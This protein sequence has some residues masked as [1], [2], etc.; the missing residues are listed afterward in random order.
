[1]STIWLSTLVLTGLL[2]V[3]AAIVLLFN[4]LLVVRKNVSIRINQQREICVISG[5]KLL[6]YLLSNEIR[7]PSACAGAGTCGLCKVVVTSGGGSTLPTEHARLSPEE[8]SQGVRLACQLS[9]KEDLSLTLPDDI[10]AA[11]QFKA[12]IVSTK[13][14]APLI[15]E[16]TLELVDG[17][18]FEFTPGDFVEVNAPAFDLPF[19]NIALDEQFKAVWNDLKISQLKA[20]SE[21]PESRAYSIAS[22]PE[23]AGRIVLLIRLAVPPPGK[24]KSI[25]PGKV[26]SW[27]F[28]LRVGDEITLT[29]PYGGF[30]LANTDR[31]KIMIGG[32]VGLAPLRAMAYHYLQTNQTP[33]MHFFYGARSQN[34]LFIESEFETLADRYLNFHWHVAL[35][36]LEPD[37][38]W[39]GHTGFIHTVLN[40][41]FLSNYQHPNNCDYYLCGP[42]LMMQAV[43][44]SL[45]DAGVD[46]K[47]VYADDFGV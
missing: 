41:K 24:E 19:I 44:A 2:S 9:V 46:S 23:D 20:V 1:M 37:S 36:D 38:S 45:A 40:N 22:R 7:I 17:D 8:I 25:P 11:K 30:H 16:I 39:S 33:E 12:H 5:G 29:G 26:S 6:D 3:L 32:G 34:D 35:S 14:V 18:E 47:H 43:K 28:G 27:L 15:K 21:S 31:D 13:H 42:P 10:A 4:R